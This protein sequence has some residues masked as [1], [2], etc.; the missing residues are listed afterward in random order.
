MVE[1]KLPRYN[2]IHSTGLRLVINKDH[3]IKSLSSLQYIIDC[4]SFAR[5]L[6]ASARAKAI[7]VRFFETRSTSAMARCIT[8]ISDRVRIEL[9][10]Q[11][12]VDGDLDFAEPVDAAGHHLAVLHRA[13]TLGGAGHDEV[14]G[15]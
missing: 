10:R 3:Q 1:W 13:D 12:L 11:R 5:P 9:V 15:P 7:K 2:T 14:A 4:L 6:I 8:S